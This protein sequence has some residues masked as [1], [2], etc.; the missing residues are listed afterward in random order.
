MVRS[1]ADRL[2]IRSFEDYDIIAS[3]PIRE[4]TRYS[5]LTLSSRS[6]AVDVPWFLDT[7][8]LEEFFFSDDHHPCLRP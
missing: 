2:G 8:H 4:H 1:L 5:Q 7:R 6:N 3:Y